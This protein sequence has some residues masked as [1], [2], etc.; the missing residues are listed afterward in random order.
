MLKQL[1]ACQFGLVHRLPGL[2]Q[3]HIGVHILVLRIK[4]DAGAG[5]YAQHRLTD[6]RLF[7]GGRQQAVQRWQDMP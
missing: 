4:G 6:L 1:R 7:G 3:Q 5:R 2:A